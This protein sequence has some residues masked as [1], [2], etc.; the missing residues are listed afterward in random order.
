VLRRI[1]LLLAAATLL[2]AGVP[3]G[4]TAAEVPTFTARGSV[5]QVWVTGAEPDAT[6]RLLRDDGTAAARRRVDRQGATLFRR[7]APGAYRVVVAGR[8]GV[9]RAPVAVVAPTDEPDP[10]LYTSQSLSDGFG[11]IRTRDGTL[12]SANVRLPGPVDDGPYPTVVEYSGYDPSN[13]DG[14]QPASAIAQLLGFAT[15]GVNLRGSGC[16]GGAFDYFET[17]Q[18]LDGYD[19]IE[20][21]AA[22]PWVAHGMVGMVGISYPGVSQLFVAAT[23]PPHLAAITPLSVIDDTYQTLYPGGILNDGFAV[24]WGEDRQNDARPAASQWVRD[25]IADGDT[26]CETNQALRLQTPSVRRTIARLGP[27]RVPADDALAPAT[28]VDRINV[29]VFIAGTWQDEETGGH[30]A[31]MLDRFAPGVPLKATLTNGRH[32]DSLSADTVPRW[33]EFLDFYVARRVPHIPPTTRALATAFFAAEYGEGI[34]LPPDRFDESTDYATALASFE[35]EPA[36]RVLF[37]NGAGGPKG[38]PLASFEASF[39]AWPPPSATPDAWYLRADG[40]LGDAPTTSGGDRFAYDPDALP[41]TSEDGWEPLPHG[42]VLGWVSEPLAA[43]TVILG[44]GSVDLWLR[45]S[46]P[47]VDLEVTISEV[48]PDGHET[49]VQSGWLRASRR[50]LD[51]TRSTELRPVPTFSDADAAPLPPGEPA[52]VRVPL[53]PFGHA[54]RVGSRVRVVVQPPGGNRPAWAF[55][56]RTYDRD[57]TVTVARSRAHPSRVVLPVVAGI[58]VP[59][60]RPD[61]G[62][63]RGQPCREYV[64]ASNA[65]ERSR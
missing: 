62:S 30:F 55:D 45:A 27:G 28:F 3:T 39:P 11:Y 43:D 54:F 2:L 15:V 48:R 64:P 22:Q 25:R 7:V 32:A 23:R 50:A 63:L 51:P 57:V 38:A 40:R 53:L 24:P 1:G 46:A 37:D 60:P 33:A 65:N 17:L 59:T 4:A 8:D 12:L 41:R 58:E 6:A 10:S 14:R 18:S 34:T 21:V 16:S 35:A 36:V 47:D 56:A 13:P 42:K 5:E 49:Y 31:E 20:T 26:T 29:P 9:E 52:L 44:S 61:C 19:V